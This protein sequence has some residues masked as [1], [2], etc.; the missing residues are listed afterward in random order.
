MSRTYHLATLKIF[1]KVDITK[2]SSSSPLITLNIHFQREI[3]NL[4]DLSIFALLFNIIQNKFARSIYSCTHHQDQPFQQYSLFQIFLS[5]FQ[6]LLSLKLPVKSIN[7]ILKLKKKCTKTSKNN[8]VVIF[9]KLWTSL[10][11][12]QK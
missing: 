7:Q 3:N 12:R 5:F 6:L 8:K 11:P 4:Q 1:W 10:L 2:F 9:W